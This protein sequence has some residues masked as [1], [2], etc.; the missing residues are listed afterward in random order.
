MPEPRPQKMAEKHNFESIYYTNPELMPL[1]DMERQF[2]IDN[3]N[4]MNKKIHKKTLSV[5]Q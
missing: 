2:K 4:I 1:N 5:S 3:V